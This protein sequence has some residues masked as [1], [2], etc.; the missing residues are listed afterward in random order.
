[1]TRLNGTEVQCAV[2]DQMIFD[3]VD[4]IEY[5]SKF[6]QLEPGDVLVTGTPGGVGIKRNPPLWMK[7]GD[8]VEVETSGVGLL[9]N[10]IAAE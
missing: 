5:N 1:M 6:T 9:R 10:Q 3:F 4:Q 8:T 2:T 7:D